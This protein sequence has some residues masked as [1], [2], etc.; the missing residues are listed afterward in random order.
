MKIAITGATGF[1]GRQLVPM[2]QEDGHELVLVGQSESELKAAF[3]GSNHV[4]YAKLEV[5]VPN[6]DL[7][8]HLDILNNDSSADLDEFR[9]INVD[10]LDSVLQASRGAKVSKLVILSTVHVFNEADQ[11]PY[12]TSRREA[13]ALANDFADLDI[14]RL[15]LPAAYGQTY[16]GK[17]TFLNKLPRPFAKWVFALI[18]CLS[19]TIAIERIGHFIS[20]ELDGVDRSEVYLSDSKSKNFTYMFT[21]RLVDVGFALTVIVCF[22]WLLLVTWVCVKLTSTGP[23][24]FKQTRVG[25]YGAH[26]TCYKF[27][28]MR[29]DTDQTATH[30]ISKEAVTAVGKFLR[31]CKFDELPQVWN[32]LRGEISLVGP[33]PCLPI[34]TEL[35][36][37]RARR[38]VLEVIPGIS[39]YAQINGIDMS[40]P[41]KLAKWDER[42]VQMRSLLLDLKIILAT[43]LG[44][45][46]G[47]KVSN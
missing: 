12:I 11:S 34:Q 47:D 45:G 3:P 22:W 29:L 44:K 26:F 6:F 30:N 23:A 28:T 24:I 43:F 37:A 25:Q 46:Q 13:M 8:V 9:R 27:R 17:L 21:K 7:L 35:V 20:H 10:L 33:R 39:G 40:D 15:F 19:P 14:I 36:D 16:S 18:S 1:I 31:R 32:I 38:G 2:L 41:E 42:Y 4:N 5:S